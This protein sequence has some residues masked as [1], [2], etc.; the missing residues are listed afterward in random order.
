MNFKFIRHVLVFVSY[1]HVIVAVTRDMHELAIVERAFTDNFV[2]ADRKVDMRLIIRKFVQS[3]K[4]RN[5]KIFVAFV[6]R[7]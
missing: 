4:I 1:F 5:E 7:Q 6:T 2:N 3:C